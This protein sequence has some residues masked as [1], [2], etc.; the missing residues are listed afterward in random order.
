M[1]KNMPKKTKIEQDYSEYTATIE[2]KTREELNKINE[3]IER[4]KKE[5]EKVGEALESRVNKDESKEGE[6]S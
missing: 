2:R 4:V 5:A 3:K 6:K 1:E